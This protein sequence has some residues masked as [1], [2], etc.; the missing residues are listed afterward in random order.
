MSKVYT[1]KEEPQNVELAFK[2]ARQMLTDPLVDNTRVYWNDPLNK[3]DKIPSVFHRAD[4]IMNL[5]C[6]ND[7]F[8][9]S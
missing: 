9:D 3:Q 8:E 5:W 7:R 2:E 1:H 4:D 6:H